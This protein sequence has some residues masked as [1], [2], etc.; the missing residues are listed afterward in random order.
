M[1]RWFRRRASLNSERRSE[2][3]APTHSS[4]LCVRDRSRSGI[5]FA[6]RIFLTS[7]I[8]YLTNTSTYGFFAFNGH[9]VG[10]KMT[11]RTVDIKVVDAEPLDW[12]TPG[13]AEATLFLRDAPQF[14]NIGFRLVLGNT[15]ET[16]AT[17][18]GSTMNDYLPIENF[19][20]GLRQQDPAARHLLALINNFA[21]AERKISIAF[22]FPG[23]A[24]QF[25]D[26]SIGAESSLIVVIPVVI[27]EGEGPGS[28]LAA[29][30][31]RPKENSKKKKDD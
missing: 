3:N 28:A 30:A 8:F 2:D 7:A 18:I 4:N 10:S 23:R 25:Y 16:L 19:E 29:L 13:F 5:A 11:K 12:H 31:P 22:I 21:P 24:D 6:I 15:K 20:L 17:R 1:A 27:Q 9:W 14:T 26:Y